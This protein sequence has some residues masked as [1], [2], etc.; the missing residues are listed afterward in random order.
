MTL[1]SFLSTKRPFFGLRKYFLVPASL[2]L[3]FFLHVCDVSE[4]IGRNIFGSTAL[5]SNLILN[6]ELWLGQVQWCQSIL[7][8]E[9]G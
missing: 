8:I 3:A 7:N 9:R 4:L 5:N 1:K 6:T 2:F